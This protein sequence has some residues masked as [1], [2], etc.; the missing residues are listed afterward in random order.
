MSQ[1]LEGILSRGV[2]Q[3]NVGDYYRFI[4][5][6]R[7]SEDASVGG[8]D[9]GVAGGP[10][11]TALRADGVGEHI[12]NGVLERP[13]GNAIA[14]SVLALRNGKQVHAGVRVKQHL[15]SSHD[16]ESNQFRITPFV[17]DNRGG[18]HIIQVEQRDAVPGT[19]EPP[20]HLRQLAF[21]VA[22]N[23]AAFAIKDDQAI[24]PTPAPKHG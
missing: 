12:V 23:N 8:D 24:L 19:E 20:I 2:L 22:M 15:R 5:V 11:S 9:F 18:T 10:F 21:P 1:T 7:E 6:V 17:A 3:I 13:D 16:R 4:T 14:P